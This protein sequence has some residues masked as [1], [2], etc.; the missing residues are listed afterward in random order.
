MNDDLLAFKQMKWKAILKVGIK[1][2]KENSH[3]IE[4][5]AISMGVI[6]N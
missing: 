1:Q 3:K 6:E 2:F 5:Y 4:L